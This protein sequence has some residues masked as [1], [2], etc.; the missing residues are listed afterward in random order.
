MRIPR[1]YSCFAYCRLTPGNQK[2]GKAAK[3]A[4]SVFSGA[5]TSREKELVQ[6]MSG[7]DMSRTMLGNVKVCNTSRQH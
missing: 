6:A 2:K 4:V 1:A 3:Q 5:A 7:D